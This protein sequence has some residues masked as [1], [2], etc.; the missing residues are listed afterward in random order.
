VLAAAPEITKARAMAVIGA[1]AD[2]AHALKHLGGDLDVIEREGA[3]EVRIA[4]RAFTVK[5]SFVRDAQAATITD[6]LHHLKKALL[7]LHAPRDEVVGVEN[8]TEIFVNAR[9]PKSFVS[10]DDADHLLSRAEDAEYAA[11]VIAAWARRYVEME[12]ANREHAPEGVVRVSEADPAGFR[13]DITAGEH[14]LASD[15]PESIGGTDT[16]PSPYGLVAAGLGACTSMT[17]RMYARRKGWPLESVAVDVRHEKVHAEDCA[18]CEE[19]GGRID[20]FERVVRLDGDLSADQRARLLEIADKCPVHRTLE[21][22]AR[23]DTREA[24]GG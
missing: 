22:R 16:A 4:G 13:Q 3:A 6:R 17:I 2:P 14:S 11:D 21:A 23:I 24:P 12:P 19:R 9:H 5:R 10:L 1:P 8:A 15:E 7:I 20:R 18:D